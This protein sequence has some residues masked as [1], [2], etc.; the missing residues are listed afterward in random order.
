[1]DYC[2]C[3]K[4]F[5]RLVI[6]LFSMHLYKFQTKVF[7]SQSVACHDSAILLL[8]CNRELVP[9]TYRAA[10]WRVQWSIERWFKSMS[11]WLISWQSVNQTPNTCNAS[12]HEWNP[13]Q[14]SCVWWSRRKQNDYKMRRQAFGLMF[15]ITRQNTELIY[16]PLHGSW[17]PI[18]TGYFSKIE[19]LCF[20]SFAN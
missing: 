7:M 16:N 10:S 3:W 6:M 19:L 20:F 13:T 12:K 15:Q 2:E 8:S 5:Y 11:K 4:S 14:A 1:M 9:A 18:I 17:I